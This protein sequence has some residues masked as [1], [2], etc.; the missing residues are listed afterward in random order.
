MTASRPR[1]DKG[2]AHD[3][4]VAGRE[5]CGAARV[6]HGVYRFLETGLFLRCASCPAEIAAACESRD[7][8]AASCPVLAAAVEGLRAAILAEPWVAETDR[9]LVA[10]YLKTVAVLALI[11]RAVGLDGA[12]VT[13]EV[14]RPRPDRDDPTQSYPK[15]VVEHDVHPLLRLRPAYTAKLKDLSEALGLSPKGRHGLGVFRP[16]AAAREV[17]LADISR[18]GSADDPEKEQSHAE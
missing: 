14:E 8:S 17:S 11:D 12:L 16:D 1:A 3:L 10:E 15:K 2:A 4:T 18:E 5:R 13:R 6:K 7:E 9:P